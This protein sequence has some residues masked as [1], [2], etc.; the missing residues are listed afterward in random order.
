MSKKRV[1][2]FSEEDRRRT[3]DDRVQLA[4]KE[5][6][7]G[8]LR[9]NRGVTPSVADPGVT[10]P[11]DATELYIKLSG[12]CRRHGCLMLRRLAINVSPTKLEA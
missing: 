7:P 11:S 12:V 4:T 1:A 3:R 2:R 8:F 6:S 9:K 5:R 10:H